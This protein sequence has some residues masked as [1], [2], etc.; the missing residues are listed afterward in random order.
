MVGGGLI[1][2]DG[3]TLTGNGVT[4]INTYPTGSQSAFDT[5]D[6]QPGSTINL[7]AQTSGSLAGIVLF[8]DRT[9]KSGL[10]QFSFGDGSTLSGTVYLPRNE[11][12]FSAKSTSPNTSI[13]GALLAPVITVK[14]QVQ[15]VIT[16][17]TSGPLATNKKVSLIE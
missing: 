11:V 8:E 1:V 13:A 15:L 9:A 17:A 6:F 5:F 3:A 7:T 2:E 4:I 16:G 14:K 10:N 12:Y